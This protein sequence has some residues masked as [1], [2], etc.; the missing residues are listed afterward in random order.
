M[1]IVDVAIWT[2]WI[3]CQKI[4]FSMFPGGGGAT[5]ILCLEILGRSAF[6]QGQITML[7]QSGSKFC[8]EPRYQSPNISHMSQ[9]PIW[10]LPKQVPCLNVNLS[11]QVTAAATAT[12]T[13]TAAS[14]QL[15]QSGKSPGPSRTGTKYP[16]RESLTST[17]DTPGIEWPLMGLRI[18]GDFHWF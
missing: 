18:L 15:S 12:A 6:F 10:K 4:G 9:I 3:C 16:V 8:V 2:F 7:D 5:N 11:F 1:D 14:Q 13:A 17:K